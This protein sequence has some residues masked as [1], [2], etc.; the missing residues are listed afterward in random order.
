MAKGT[1]TIE[2]YGEI[3]EALGNSR[4]NVELENGVTLK[5]CIISGKIRKNFIRL[6]P[7]DRVKMAL[8][9]YDLTTGRIEERL[10]VKGQQQQQPNLQNKNNKNKKGKKK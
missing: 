3:V 8:S 9:V 2:A 1:D 4:F 7:G 6:V 5:N 10:L